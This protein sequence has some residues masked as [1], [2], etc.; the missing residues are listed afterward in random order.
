MYNTSDTRGNNPS[1]GMNYQKVGRELFTPDELARLP[2]NKCILQIRGV[3]PFCSEKYDI[4]KHP[5]YKYLADANPKLKYDV[6]RELS[7]RAAI[8]KSEECEFIDLR[9]N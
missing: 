7:T 6:A 2:G 9:D 4:E 1:Y 3:K 8:S 5:R